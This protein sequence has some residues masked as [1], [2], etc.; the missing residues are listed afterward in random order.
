MQA[1]VK[2]NQM[3]QETAS[4]ASTYVI[5]V[6][7]VFSLIAFTFIVNFPGYVANPIVQLTQSIK[8]IAEKNYEERL[9]FN[10]KDEF[11]EL[12]EAFNQMAEKLDEYEHSNLAGILFEKKRNR[13]DHQPDVGSCY[14]LGRT[15]K[16]C[17]C[18]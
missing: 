16:S 10:R 17:L 6:V 4:K 13:N 14:W 12:A 9:H 2:K 15:E 7:T 1:I 8:S 5:I 3:T 18:K 11:E